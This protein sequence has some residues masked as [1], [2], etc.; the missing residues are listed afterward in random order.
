MNTFKD[1][2]IELGV[3]YSA[4]L[5]RF[6]GKE[7]F[8]QKVTLKFLKDTNMQT[9]EDALARSDASTAFKATHTLKGLA[10]N[11]GF[12][13]LLVPLTPM[14]EILRKGSLD[15]IDPLLTQLRERYQA[16]MDVLRSFSA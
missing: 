4:T 5:A 3:D 7:D 16:T 10:A 12:D 6:L 11:L 8:Y 2:M 15:G 14:V 13:A 1:A 9:L